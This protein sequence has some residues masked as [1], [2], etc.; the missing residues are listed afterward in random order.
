MA[1]A[2]LSSAVVRLWAETIFALAEKQGAAD[3]MLEEWQALLELLEGRRDLGRIFGSPLVPAEAKKAMVEK[4]FRGRFSDLLVDSLQ[5]MRSKGRLGLLRAVAAAYRVEW[6]E[7]RNQKEVVVTT[8][9]PLSPEQRREVNA[10]A[11]RFANAEAILVEK[12][13]PSLLGGFVLRSGDRKFDRTIRT[14]IE[15]VQ[16]TFLARATRELLDGSESIYSEETSRG[17]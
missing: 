15:R 14:E 8:A 12:I 1:S 2:A 6:L 7:R 13:D 4:A 16:A 5:V 3:S 17:V 10:A 11:S 9:L